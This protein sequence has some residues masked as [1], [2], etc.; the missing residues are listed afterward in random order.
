MSPWFAWK[1]ANIS[2]SNVPNFKFNQRT[3]HYLHIPC[4]GF[5]VQ[6]NQLPI[7]NTS[8]NPIKAMEESTYLKVFFQEIAPILHIH[9]NR[10]FSSIIIIFRPTASTR[11]NFM[12]VAWDEY[13]FLI[14]QL[15][16]V[17]HGNTETKHF[18]SLTNN[19]CIFLHIKTS[20]DTV[21]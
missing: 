19:I 20:T 16:A 15:R 8:H 5:L 6:L 13:S 3:T 7:D 14:R 17:K 11:I 12:E 9:N 4:E 1:Q 2:S 18:F 10:N 21:Y